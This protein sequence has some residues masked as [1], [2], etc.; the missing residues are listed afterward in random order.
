MAETNGGRVSSLAFLNTEGG[1]ALLAQQYRVVIENVESYM[2]SSI[3]KNQD[4]SGDFEAGSVEAKR[5]ANA[6]SQPYGTAAANGMGADIQLLPVNVPINIHKEIIENLERYDAATLGVPDLIARRTRNHARTMAREL[7]RAFFACAQSAGTAFT[8]T[9]SDIEAILEDL[10]QT[11][12]T[13][14]NEFVDGVPRDMIHLVC[15]PAFYGQI[16]AYLDKSYNANI[17]T[18]VDDFFAFHGARTYASTYLPTGVNCIAMVEGAVAQPVR[19]D[20]YTATPLP[21]GNNW[22]LKLFYDFGTTAVMPDLIQVYSAASTLETLVVS[23]VK[24]PTAG[25]TKVA[26]NPTQPASGNKYVY[27]LGSAPESVAYQA[28]LSTGWTD[29]PDDGIIAASTNTYITVAEA[30]SST[31]AVGV[32]SSP[33]VKK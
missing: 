16:R 12:E 31:K 14:Q 25:S 29:M 2:L 6:I 3:L 19:S 9:E 23:S 22:A 4:L 13:T 20:V 5:F 26:V 7:E 21:L 10:I 32:G 27:K 15:S 18:D 11:I 8:T 1:L 30:D 24:G 17:Q 33:I 28:D